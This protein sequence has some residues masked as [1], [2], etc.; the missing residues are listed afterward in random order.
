MEWIDGQ[1][2]DGNLTYYKLGKRDQNDFFFPSSMSNWND[3]H[4][5]SHEKEDSFT[6]KICKYIPSRGCDSLWNYTN[7]K[8]N[9]KNEE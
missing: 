9:V 1:L 4:I 3:C 8:K 5:T 6:N 7:T 2:C